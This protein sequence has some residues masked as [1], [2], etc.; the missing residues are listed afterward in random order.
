MRGCACRGESAGFVHLEC[1]AQF[2]R[3][4]EEVSNDLETVLYGFMSCVNCKQNFKGALALEMVRRLWRRYRSAQ[5]LTLRYNSVRHL[6]YCLGQQGDIDAS[7]YLFDE[8]F[9]CAGGDMQRVLDLQIN[10]AYLLPS[11]GHK[12]EALKILRATLPAAKEYSADKYL[13]IEAHHQTADILNDLG[14]YQESLDMGA[15]LISFAEAKCGRESEYTLNARELHALNCS[16]LGRVEETK[17]IFEDILDPNPGP[18]PRP[19][20]DATYRPV[21]A[22]GPHGRA[23]RYNRK[24]HG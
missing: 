7:N 18:W 5:N 20:V 2:A 13:Y 11:N 8:A 24:R 14:Q 12:L 22:T 21:F 3:K 19:S 15:E 1:L 4:K 10:R 23:I 17:A 16:H 6:A 9:K